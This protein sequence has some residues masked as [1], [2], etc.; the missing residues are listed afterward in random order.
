MK[1]ME[2]HQV[3]EAVVLHCIPNTTS[4]R[5]GRTW[6]GLVMMMMENHRLLFL[7]NERKAKRD[8]KSDSTSNC[9]DES[10]REQKEMK[11]TAGLIQ[12]FYSFVASSHSLGL[13][14]IQYMNKSWYEREEKAVVI[15]WKVCDVRREECR[16][17]WRWM[18]WKQGWN[19]RKVRDDDRTC[20][21]MESWW[22]SSRKNKEGQDRKM[23]DRPNFAPYLFDSYC[24]DVFL[25]PVHMIM[26][27]VLSFPR[28]LALLFLSWPFQVKKRENVTSEEEERIKIDYFKR[29]LIRSREET[30]WRSAFEEGKSSSWVV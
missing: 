16:C 13:N 27:F 7:W 2:M 30:T 12:E 3:M 8:E 4:Q 25:H 14:T 18:G 17:G 10:W 28:H 11:K 9:H 5:N 1:I 26:A 20:F 6:N 23:K 19:N 21:C 15:E 24:L 29:T 22:S